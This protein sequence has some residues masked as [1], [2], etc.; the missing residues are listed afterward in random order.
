M[1]DPVDPPALVGSLLR[2]CASREFPLVR[3]GN[4]RKDQAAVLLNLPAAMLFPAARMP[5]AALSGLLLRLGCWDESHRI[6]QDLETSE[7]SYWHGIAHR[8][9]PDAS[10][11][12]YWFRRVGLHAIFPALRDRAVQILAE[13][14][15]SGWRLSKDWDPFLLIDWCNEARSSPGSVKEKIALEIQRSE[16]DLLYAWCSQ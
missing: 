16:W 2:D 8:I 11:S 9:E 6:S 7:G 1:T 12:A 3:K 14:P 13:S 4:C 5:D 15:E 10:N